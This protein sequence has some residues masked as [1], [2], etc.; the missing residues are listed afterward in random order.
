MYVM[1]VCMYVMYVCM[2][3]CVY[4][5]LYVCMYIY[6]C[7]LAGMCVHV[8]MHTRYIRAAHTYMHAD[9]NKRTELEQND[10]QTTGGG[11]KRTPALPK[12]GLLW[13]GRDFV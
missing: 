9:T 1:Y 11:T 12:A 6:I 3:V 2:Y 4:V 7:V 8:F 10:A 13:S 5:C